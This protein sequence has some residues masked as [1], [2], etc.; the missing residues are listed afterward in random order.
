LKKEIISLRK[1]LNKQG[2]IPQKQ[3][4]KE[5]KAKKK[6]SQLFNTYQLQPYV[7]KLAYIGVNYQGLAIQAETDNTIE[8][9]LFKALKKTSLVENMGD[10][11]Y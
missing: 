5:E 1:S 8:N 9:E 10:C 6:Q 7:F 2:F 4:K 3:K 11:S